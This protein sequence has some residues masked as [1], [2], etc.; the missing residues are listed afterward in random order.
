V[1]DPLTTALVAA[2]GATVSALHQ[3][4]V[5]RGADKV[6]AQRHKRAFGD[7]TKVVREVEQELSILRRTEFRDVMDDEWQAA[8]LTAAQALDAA[9]LTKLART[10]P[11]V[12]T[13]PGR[14][15]AR[16]R[17]SG[18][19][20]LAS[21][22]LGDGGVE[23]YERLLDLGCERLA[24]QMRGIDEIMRTVQADTA[25]Q[26]AELKDSVNALGRSVSDRE[27]NRTD[28]FEHHY[29]SY[30]A[31]EHATF[32]LFQVSAG[33]APARQ[34]FADSYT[35]PS[36]ARRQRT[37]P[38]LA[39]TGAGAQGAHV[40]AGAPRVLLLGGAGAGKTTFLRWLAHT[41]A[42]EVRDRGADANSPWQGV[43]PFFVPLRQFTESGLPDPEDLVRVA[44]PA[45]A[46]EK[47]DGWVSSLLRSGRA[48][49]LVDGVDEVLFADR[50]R[51]RTWLA[52]MLR[53]YPLARYVVSSRPSA[54]DG[55]WLTSD[56]D[57]LPRYE[58]LPLSG[59]GLTA[60]IGHW[61]AAARSL[62][63][64]TVQRE[65]LTSCEQRLS[66]TLATRP[67]IRGLVA[68]PLLCSLLC[69]LYR[70]ENMYLPQSRKD[71]LDKALELLLSEWDGRRG[72]LVEDEL[73]MSD[74]EKIILLERFAAPMVRNSQLLVTHDEAEKRFA[75]AM[76]GLRSQGV[77]PALVLRHMLERSGLLRQNDLD[78]RIQFVHRTFRDFLAAGEFV[79][80][81]ELGYLID[82][83]HDDSLHEVVFMAAAQARAREAGDLLAGLL[84]R[85]NSRA[86]RK[87]PEITDRLELLAAASLGYVDVIDPEHVRIKVMAA[88]HRLIPPA[89]F[90]QAEMLAKAGS[91][92]LDLLP[93]PLEIGRYSEESGTRAD[94]AARVIRTLALIGGEAAWDKIHAFS[95]TH[96]GAVIDELLRAWRQNGYA[97]EYARTLLSNVD[98]GELVLEVHR[99]DVLLRLRHLRSL[100]SV[101]LIGNIPL[102]DRATGLYPLAELPSLRHIEIKSNEVA[103]D[104]HGLTG[105][106]TLRSVEVSGYHNAI[107]D[108][109]ALAGLAV[110]DLRLLTG[111]HDGAAVPALRT[112]TG[113]PLHRLHIRHPA[114][115]SGLAGPGGLPHDLPLTELTVDIRLE[116][117]NLLGIGHW[118]HL[119]TVTAYGVPRAE[120]VEALAELP[121]LR[122]VVLHHVRD[123]EQVSRL[124]ALVRVR[125]TLF[126]VPTEAE[127][128]VREAL[129]D[130]ELLVSVAA[131]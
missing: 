80:A 101:Q 118:P 49:L 46:G 22:A 119:H 3:W 70:R 48:M 41:T 5:E 124:R 56:T 126:D 16:V 65:W 77:E 36:I 72:V 31:A 7:V 69:A 85:A 55:S 115:H 84:E 38:D 122:H 110:T 107:E 104:L 75:R 37:Q 33:R 129:P 128:A 79:K 24:R 27:R 9:E 121:E 131:G 39:L 21:A 42:A 64:D 120:E 17:R 6:V 66:Q 53:G 40:I 51:V 50:E 116:D 2:L 32:E 88:V 97:E 63:A 87:D 89:G 26:V 114:L 28:S 20:A 71:L 91:F 52:G 81:G 108:L 59:N 117:R 30:V 13:A 130:A 106:T 61:F 113:A 74:K 92:V 76:S 12:L 86:T 58:L 105:C 23:V 10:E 54:V 43:V 93:G 11:A 18:R 112:L 111:G 82:H 29:V 83:A 60:L 19:A 15:R 127:K 25:T 78:G 99:W 123:A 1:T 47:P 44:A 96:R 94:I 102:D 4:A 14:L 90:D 109:S 67:D 34:E 68:S 98:F 35:V 103:R 62:E 125:L 73:R 8:Q 100:A 57:G 45:L 95:D